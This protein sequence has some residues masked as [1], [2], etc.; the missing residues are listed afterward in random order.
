MKA[1]CKLAFFIDF[2]SSGDNMIHVN[3]CLK[4]FKIVYAK[5]RYLVMTREE[6]GAA[7]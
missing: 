7:D 5:F 1:G 2:F 4:P 6:R 3:N